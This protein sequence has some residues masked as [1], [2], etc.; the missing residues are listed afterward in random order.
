MCTQSHIYYRR[1]HRN[2]ASLHRF[3][4]AMFADS[5]L[6]SQPNTKHTNLNFFGLM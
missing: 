6:L 1:Y 2:L 5:I 4:T 3:D